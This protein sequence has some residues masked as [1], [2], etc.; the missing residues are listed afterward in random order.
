MRDDAAVDGLDAGETLTDAE[1]IAHC[2][3]NL[4]GFKVPQSIVYTDTLP[5]SGGGK[6]LK[7]EL[8][9]RF[10]EAMKD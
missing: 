7:Q 9:Q 3:A 4:A 10:G 1:V 6:V 5:R 8:R 2:R